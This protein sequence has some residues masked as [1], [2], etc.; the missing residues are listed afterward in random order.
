MKEFEDLK[1]QRFDN[2][3][4]RQWEDLKMAISRDDKTLFFLFNL[5]SQ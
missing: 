1:I 3:I 4:I 2:L 5:S